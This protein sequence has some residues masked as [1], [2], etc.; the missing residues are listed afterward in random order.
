[1]PHLELGCALTQSRH[2][3]SRLSAA[4]PVPQAIHP[5]AGAVVEARGDDSNADTA[6]AAS[7]LPSRKPCRRT[8][9][10]QTRKER[11]D[12]LEAKIVAMHKTFYNGRGY[13]L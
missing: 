12:A 6:A 11:I 10:K 3:V 13:G 8:S 1:M 9:P 4:Q 5:A 7:N 2:F